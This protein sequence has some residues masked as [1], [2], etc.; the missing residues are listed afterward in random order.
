MRVVNFKSV[1]LVG[2]VALAVGCGGGTGENSLVTGS[3]PSSTPLNT[4]NTPAVPTDSPVVEPTQ[5]PVPQPTTVTTLVPTVAPSLAPTVSPSLVPTASPTA[6]PTI[7]P[8]AAPTAIPT[9]AP[10]ALPTA[11]PTVAPTAAPTTTPTALP[12]TAPTL[13]PTV[14]PTAEPTPIPTPVPTSVGSKPNNKACKG[15]A[16]AEMATQTNIETTDGVP[17]HQDVS[18]MNEHMAMM[19]LVDYQLVTHAVIADGDWCSASIWAE[20]AIPGDDARVLI[21]EGFTVTLADVAGARLDTLRVDGSLI[22]SSSSSS[23][24][25]VDT[26]VVGTLGDWIMGTE[27][28]PVQE[29][30]SA[31]IVIADNGDIDVSWDPM[32]L[33]RG[34]I[35]HGHTAIH[36]QE[37]TVH[38]KVSQDPSRGD[39][40][41]TLVKAPTN[42][43]VGDT[44]VIA[45]T[46]YMG[47]GWDGS[48]VSYAGTQDE[49][50]TI[51]SINRNVIT[52]DSALTYDHHSPRADLKTSVANF[53][54]NV[55]I[56]S[57][58][59]ASLPVHRRGHL[60]FMH[61]KNVDVR[62]AAFDG[63]GRTDK[64]V[65]SFD[66]GNIADVKADSN[67]RGRYSFHFHRSGTDDHRNPAMAIGNAVFGSPGWGYVHHDSHAMFH[68]NAS[69][70]TFGA[71]FVAETGNE[72]G[73]WSNNIAIKAEGNKKINPKLGNDEHKFD[74]GRSGDG[75]WFTGRLVKSFDNIAASVETGF[76]YFHRDH[77]GT[78]IH[79]DPNDYSLSDAIAL[80]DGTVHV[81]DTPIRG[82]EDNEA[83]AAKIGLFVGKG[84]P[85][86]GHDIYTVFSTLTAWE[87]RNGVNLEYTGHYLL[88]DFDLIGTT[89][90]SQLAVDFGLNTFD[91]VLKNT[92]IHHFEEGIR[93]YKSHANDKVEYMG[94][95]QYVLVG[96][97]ITDVEHTYVDYNE[98]VDKVI[99]LNNLSLDRFELSFDGIGEDRVITSGGSVSFSGTKKDSIGT[100][101]LP[102]GGD[103]LEF[104]STHFRRI[105]TEDG[106]YTDQASGDYYLIFRQYFSDRATGELHKV[107]FKTK[108]NASAVDAVDRGSWE[109]NDLG[110]IDLNSKAPVAVDD[111]LVV[112]SGGAITVNLT[113]ND[114]DVDGDALSMDGYEPPIHGYIINNQDGTI[115]YRSAHG[116]TGTDSFHYW[117]T[118]NQGNFSRA[119]VLVTVN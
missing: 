51:A 67:A 45:G 63:L 90:D 19:E 76:T 21:P 26:M 32:L 77:T 108:L 43:H 1:V 80:R 47:W 91:M 57:E 95:D 112:N 102:G 88:T 93:L 86:Q 52:L 18:K 69:Y 84:N 109:A 83:F 17:N 61:S 94:R 29:G 110:T 75:F 55:T 36:G 58:N 44:L 41:L 35:A 6:L 72:I 99:N 5:I 64:S 105:L 89:N 113:A 24:L 115:E 56:R 54:R 85:E 104:S 2:W 31:E 39:T 33:S 79:V 11:S 12:T 98:G 53:T 38:L 117:V 82:F 22:F 13:A 81:E 70:N 23:Q 34:I 73:I 37:K 87:V 46:S 50:K 16:L 9:V 78:M 101:P 4:D 10:T 62:Y 28:N 7:A 92:K 15:L 118:D 25:T 107:G 20:G 27:E 40:T 30:V 49:V 97:T 96:N 111:L 71:G 42:W 14:V 114:L 106:Y 65:E 60:M 103:K 74:I 68:N 66:I 116:F 59:A 119:T 3:T 100:N 8:T 48:A